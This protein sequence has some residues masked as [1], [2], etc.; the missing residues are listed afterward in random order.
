MIDYNEIINPIKNSTRNY[1]LWWC[2]AHQW[3][4][5]ADNSGKCV[6]CDVSVKSSGQ[7]GNTGRCVPHLVKAF[8]NWKQME[9]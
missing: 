1:P 8:S 2:D 3:S 4:I 5:N 6:R 7:L 9:T